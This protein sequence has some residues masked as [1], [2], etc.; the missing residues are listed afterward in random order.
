MSP[1]IEDSPSPG[2]YQQFKNTV[3]KM[4]REVLAVYY[5]VQDPEV[6]WLP[7]VVAAIALGYG[8]SPID[9]IPDFIPILGLIDDLLI[10]PGELRGSSH[11]CLSI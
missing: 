4:K 6:G 5:A 11:R 1:Q 3:K 7:K 10:L 8:L 2:W 9:L